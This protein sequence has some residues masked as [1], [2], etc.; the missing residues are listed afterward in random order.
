[1]VD[2]PLTTEFEIQLEEVRGSTSTRAGPNLSHVLPRPASKVMFGLS[3]AT[4]IAGSPAQATLSMLE[5]NDVVVQLDATG[6]LVVSGSSEHDGCKYDSLNTLLLNCSPGFVAKFNESLFA[7]L[8]EA[9]E[10]EPP[11]EWP[12]DEVT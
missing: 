11:E 10:R 7:H 4:A 3:G 9:Q 6:F 12:D 1:M 2:H 5:G 8:R